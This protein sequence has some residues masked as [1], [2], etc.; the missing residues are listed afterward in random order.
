MSLYDPEA[1]ANAAEYLR[2]DPVVLMEV[3]S[4]PISKTAVWVPYAETGY[5][6]GE[7]TGD[8]AAG[9][10]MVKR[11]VDGKEKEYKEAEVEPRNPSKYELMEDMAN[12]TYLSEAAVV[13][14]LNER[15]KRFLIYTYSG[16]IFT[17]IVYSSTN[18]PFRSFLCYSQSLQMA[19]SIR[20]TCCHHLPKQEKD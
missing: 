17:V 9:M 2:L 14:N 8:G 19:S 6:K 1:A 18:T 12:M 4:A 16:K 3:R 11:D 15:Y 5:T 7:V 10:K 20:S 13:N